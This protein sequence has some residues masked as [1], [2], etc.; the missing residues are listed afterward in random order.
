MKDFHN[1]AINRMASLMAFRFL[2]GE[3]CPICGH[4]IE[5]LEDIEK[6]RPV[7]GFLGDTAVCKKCFPKYLKRVEFL[8]TLFV[9]NYLFE[10]LMRDASFES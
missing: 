10:E 2:Q 8:L 6:R 1:F 3:K 5:K 7:K 9:G 4:V